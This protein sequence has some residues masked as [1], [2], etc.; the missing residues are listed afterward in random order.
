MISAQ[1]VTAQY[2][3]EVSPF[4]QAPIVGR[5]T[6]SRSA[7]AC[8]LSLLR[9]EAGWVRDFLSASPSVNCM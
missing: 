9:P 1:A 8:W 7:I 5:E 6:W 4:S 2:G 3:G